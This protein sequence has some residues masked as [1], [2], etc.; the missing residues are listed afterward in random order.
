MS[1]DTEGNPRH[2]SCVSDSQL[3]SIAASIA[4]QGKIQEVGETLC[5]NPEPENQRSHTPSMSSTY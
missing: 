4:R 3:D 2:N 5:I 1:G